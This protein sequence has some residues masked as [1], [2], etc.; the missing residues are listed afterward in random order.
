MES[1]A[2]GE[3]PIPAQRERWVF[4]YD[5]DGDLR[6]ISHHDMLRLFAR[7]L[8]RA[9]LPVRFSEGFNPHPRLSIPLPRPVGVASQA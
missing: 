7:S 1:Q 8:A 4:G 3:I 2:L 5:V 6:F 9:A